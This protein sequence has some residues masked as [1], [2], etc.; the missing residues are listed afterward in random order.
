[1]RVLAWLA[2]RCPCHRVSVLATRMGGEGK[3]RQ[4]CGPRCCGVRFTHQRK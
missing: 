2:P 4:T 3:G 1:M